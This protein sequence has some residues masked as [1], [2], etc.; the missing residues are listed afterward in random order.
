MIGFMRR[1]PFSTTLVAGTALLLP[2]AT[3]FATPRP[4]SVPIAPTETA[5][6]LARA[7]RVT[8]AFLDAINDLRAG[9]QSPPLQFSEPLS[10]AARLLLDKALIESVTNGF[11]TGARLTRE[12]LRKSGYEPSQFADGLAS[13]TR[14]PAEIVAF[15]RQADPKSFENFLDAGLRDFG[16]AAE[17]WATQSIYALVAATS[18][19]EINRPIIEQLSALETVRQQLLDRVNEERARRHRGPLRPS[20]ALNLTAQTYAERM[21]REG[22][23]G[24]ISPRGDTV[25][26]RV[27]AS[28]YEPELTGENLAAGQ[29]TVEQAMDNWMASQGHRDN[30]LDHRFQDIGSGISVLESEGEL[31]ILWVQCFGRPKP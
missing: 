13:S 23:Y 1:R 19:S 15:W 29:P 8:R 12:D 30:I 27:Q 2:I 31:K 26:E 25:L 4:Q 10:Q 28:G 17:T 11:D 20:R 24:H 5:E 7:E 3:L 6:G 18:Q 14:D 16:L 9:D 22:F 21:M